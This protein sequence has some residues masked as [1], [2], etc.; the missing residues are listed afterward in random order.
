MKKFRTPDCLDKI[1]LDSVLQNKATCK[2][3]ALIVTN[4]YEGTDKA[5]PS[6]DLDSDNM[7]RFFSFLGNY[8]VVVPNKN[9]MVDELTSICEHLASWPYPECYRRIVIYIAGH[10]GDGFIEFRDK[11]VY[12][13]D[14]SS[15][16]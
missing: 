4:N 13:E 12:I 11:E 15:Y 6:T 1:R 5:L 2:G 16:I 9:L 7:E 3:I 10:G 14:I 8:E